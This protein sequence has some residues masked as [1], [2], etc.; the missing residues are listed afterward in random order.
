M[1]PKVTI[2]GF[3]RLE[4]RFT[5]P[6]WVE[7]PT[8][9]FLRAWQETFKA[10]AVKRA[11]GGIAKTIR[12]E[13]DSKRFPLWARV[14]SSHPGAEPLEWGTGLRS[15][16]PK[17]SRARHYPP[18][19]ALRE[20]SRSRGLNEFAVARAIYNRG[21]LEPRRFFRD[22]EK[23]ADRQLNAMLATFA[24]NIERQAELGMAAD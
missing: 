15:E 7:K 13:R 17:S 4:R 23:V 5:H 10:A 21:G 6:D 11:P 19:S 3:D 24:R 20:W 16:S 9:E 2:R 1:T 8:G 14:F 22:A 12:G 18:P